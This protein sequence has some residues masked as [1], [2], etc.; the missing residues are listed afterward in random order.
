MKFS[1]RHHVVLLEPVRAAGGAVVE[2][3]GARGGV[4]RD[5]GA[6]VIVAFESGR[7]MPVITDKLGAS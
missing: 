2:P 6:V 4:L 5:T 1:R 3:A 7:T